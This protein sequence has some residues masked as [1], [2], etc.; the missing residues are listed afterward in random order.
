MVGVILFQDIEPHLYHNEFISKKPIENDYIFILNKDML[1]LED[2]DSELSLPHYN[3]VNSNFPNAIKD[4]IYLFSIDDTAF[5]LSLQEIT[6]TDKF[7]Y[8]DI[9]LFREMKPS[10]LAFA[11]AT[12]Y[13]LAVWYDTHRFCGRCTRSLSRKTDERAVFC[14]QCG[15][16]EYPKISPVVITGIVDGDRI[17][18]TKHSTGYKRYALIS[19]FVEIGETLEAAIKREVMEEVGLQIKNIRYYKSQPWAFSS[20]LL[21]GFFAE[22]DGSDCVKI[23][24]K[25]LSK[26]VWIH[27]HSLPADDSTLS[28]TWNMIEAFRNGEV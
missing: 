10:W 1:L 21:F 24:I 26:A 6:E 5:Y 15:N 17:L 4:L 9:Q 23:D 8:Q 16:V 3:V 20:S 18:L 25:E 13:H 19:G 27:R 28:L 11:G 7:R 12:A 14:P 22:L 2:R